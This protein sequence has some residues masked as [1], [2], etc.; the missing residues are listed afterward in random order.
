MKSTILLEIIQFLGHIL[1]ITLERNLIIKCM[2]SA[3]YNVILFHLLEDAALWKV[4]PVILW[5]LIK[6][7]LEKI[8]VL[9]ANCQVK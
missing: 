5:K 8:L 9:H 7:L 6:L 1:F 2:F 3:I 4:A